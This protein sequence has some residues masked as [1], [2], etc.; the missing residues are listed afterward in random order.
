MHSEFQGFG[1]HLKFKRGEFRKDA[2]RRVI[3]A[4]EQVFDEQAHF[5]EHF[6]GSIC[7]HLLQQARKLM[8]PRRAA[9]ISLL[10]P[11]SEMPSLGLERRMLA[12]AGLHHRHEH[13]ILH[14]G[15]STK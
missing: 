7:R 12:P 10:I 9:H 2:A 3:D 1:L 14:M 13:H 11:Q 15:S 4:V 6:G 8:K 5:E